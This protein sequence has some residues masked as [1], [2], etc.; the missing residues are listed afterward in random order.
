MPGSCATKKNLLR[1]R[2]YQAKESLTV[3]PF[4]W[5]I[6]LNLPVIHRGFLVHAHREPIPL[7]PSLPNKWVRSFFLF[8]QFFRQT[9]AEKLTIQAI[10]GQSGKFS[11]RLWGHDWKFWNS[12]SYKFDSFKGIIPKPALRD[13]KNFWIKRYTHLYKFGADF[14]A[15]FLVF[16][17]I[18]ICRLIYQ[19][20]GLSL[21]VGRLWFAHRVTYSYLIRSYEDV[22]GYFRW[23]LATENQAH[24]WICTGRRH[25]RIL[26]SFNVVIV[27]WN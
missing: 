2:K 23:R 7:R 6:T 5:N 22:K 27:N 25:N 20:V 17:I 3:T 15:R 14:H 19:F 10:S 24:E 4:K 12:W 1:G 9:R 11:N 26:V 21:F 18:I 13:S 16:F 8:F